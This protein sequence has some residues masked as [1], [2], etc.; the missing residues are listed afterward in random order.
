MRASGARGRRF[1]WNSGDLSPG[2]Q[3]DHFPPLN[4]IEF[5]CERSESAATRGYAALDLRYPQGAVTHDAPTT[6]VPLKVDRKTGRTGPDRSGAWGPEP[7][8]D[9][10]LMVGDGGARGLNV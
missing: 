8:G 5:S 6:I 7:Y 3:T 2:P 4:D 10:C 1:A 9:E